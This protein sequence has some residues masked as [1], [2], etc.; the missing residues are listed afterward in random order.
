ML[1]KIKLGLGVALAVGMLAGCGAGQVQNGDLNANQD[2]DSAKEDSA[3]R[4]SHPELYKCETDADCA[5]VEKAGC[6]PN[7]YL[8]A[9]NKDQEQRYATIYA[10]TSAPAACPLFIVH[11]T[12]VA[13]CNAQTH[14]CEMIA[15]EDITCN[16]FI[17]PQYQHHCP[18]GYTCNLLARGVPDAGGKC[19]ADG[20]TPPAPVDNR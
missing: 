9:V 3:R 7:G 1:T 4:K 14:A 11:D 2:V 20:T 6:C 17:A 5:A 16:A 13:Q 18:D 8:V 10:C 15:P 19:I 12:R